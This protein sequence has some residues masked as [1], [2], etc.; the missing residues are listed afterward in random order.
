[1]YN[2]Y[3]QENDISLETQDNM[4]N[5]DTK[6]DVS[7]NTSDIIY[8]KLKGKTIVLVDSDEPWYLNKDDT[9]KIPYKKNIRL[10]NNQYTNYADFGSY[11]NKEFFNNKKCNNKLIDEDNI[12]NKDKDN[13]NIKNQI[14]I[15]L[16]LFLII[17]IIY[18]KFIKIS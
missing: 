7:N 11:E 16:L 1:M 10:I 15:L 3:Q 8:N 14:I 9:I 2:Y 18:K 13:N 4:T 17:L 6:S 5:I 12:D